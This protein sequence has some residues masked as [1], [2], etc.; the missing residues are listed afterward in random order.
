M[1][2]DSSKPTSPYFSSNKRNMIKI[3]KIT[4]IYNMKAS[5]SWGQGYHIDSYKILCALNKLDF[6]QLWN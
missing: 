2:L 6:P 1:R 5:L 4:D 3:K